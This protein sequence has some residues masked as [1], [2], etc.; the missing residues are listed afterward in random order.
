MEADIGL[1]GLAVMG[2][3]LVLNMED[4]GYS[5]AVFNRSFAK[6]EDFLKGSAQHRRILGAADLQ[7]FCSL[8]KKPRKIILMVQAGF[9]VDELIDQCL[10]FLEKGDVI[11]DGGNSYFRDTERREKKLQEKGVLF[12]GAGIS[13]GEEGA[14]IGPSI[15]PGGSK[16]AWRLVQPIFETISAKADDGTPCC[17]WVGEGGSGHYIKMVHNGIEY[18]DMQ[19]I[20]EIFHLLRDVFSCSMDQMAE[21][22][23]HWNQGELSSYLIEITA[24]ILQ[25]RDHNGSFL[26]DKILDVVHQKG[27]GKWTVASALEGHVPVTLVAE[28]VFARYLSA[29]KEEREQAHV[30]YQS[31]KQATTISHNL[32]F[33]DLHDALYAA[34]IVSYAQGFMLMRSCAEKMGWELNFGNIALLWRGGCIIRSRFLGDIQKAFLRHRDLANLLLDP[35]FSHEIQRCLH[36]WRKVVAHAALAAIPIPA[37][38]SGLSFID[39]YTCNNLPAYLLAAQRDFFGAHGYEKKD[40][41]R[42]SFFHTQW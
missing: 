12:L 36:S 18:G 7:N 9:P 42:G 10:P 34:K 6:T 1:I 35:F 39:G 8:L 40:Q 27:T 13:G 16:E 2:Q 20:C 29:L 3:N 19:L 30:L 33:K 24:S 25:H 11:V 14:R 41:P 37:L 26:L 38:A 22:F 32:T 28:S 17:A 4:H 21:M 5:V 15:M 31:G 23:T